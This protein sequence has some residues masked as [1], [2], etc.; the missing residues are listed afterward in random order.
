[1][2]SHT[3]ITLTVDVPPSSVT[4]P[5][6]ITLKSLGGTVSGGSFTYTAGVPASPPAVYAA[7]LGSSSVGVSWTAPATGGSAIT[8]YQ[9]SPTCGGVSSTTVS[10]TTNSATLTGL[11]SGASCAFRVVA[12]NAHGSGVGT[13][14]ASV[15][16]GPL[17]ASQKF[18]MAAFTDFLDRLPI[19]QELD[20]DAGGLGGGSITR[21]R[22]PTNWRR[23]PS[24]CRTS[25]S[26]CT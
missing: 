15:V 21:L 16:E 24:G 19:A 2:L 13:T 8:G 22:S 10:G 25:C 9:V 12:E 14:S 26:S 23:R 18:V 6:A 17:T 3:G 1:M 5:V 7:S 4:G 20:T 11:A